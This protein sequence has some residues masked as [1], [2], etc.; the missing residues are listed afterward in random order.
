MEQRTTVEII[1]E[2]TNSRGHSVVGG[3]A[4]QIRAQNW[5]RTI[6][7]VALAGLSWGSLVRRLSVDWS[8]NPQYGYGWSVPVLAVWLFWRRWLERP[9][10]Q[11]PRA[12]WS[13]GLLLACLLL[14]LLPARLIEEANPEWRLMLWTHALSLAAV[15]LGLVYFH[16]GNSWTKHFAFPI[17]FLLVSVPWPSAIEHELIQGL[18]QVVAAGTVRSLGVLGIVGVQH[19]NLIEVGNG[20]VGMDEACSGVRSL[21]TS[22]MI[23]LFLG[24]LYRFGWGRRWLMLSLGVLLAVVANFGRT[25]FLVWNAA[26]HGLESVERWHDSAGLIILGAVFAGQW[27]LARWLRPSGT[28]AEAVSACRPGVALSLP[29]WTLA[30]LTMWLAATE[31]GTE[32]WY[33]VHERKL[34]LSTEWFL[35]WPTDR[36]G[37]RE[38]KITDKARAIL[39]CDEGRGGAWKD[40]ARNFWLVFFLEWKAGRNSAQLAKGHTPDI[41]MPATGQRLVRELDVRTFT[42]RGVTLPFRRYEFTSDGRPLYVFHCIWERATGDESG[43]LREDWSAGSR[44]ESV[45]AGR[46]HLGQQ[47]LQIAVSGPKSTEAA[48]AALACE[49]ER[50]LRL[51]GN[52]S[53]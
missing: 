29:A 36:G 3:V 12:R 11:A 30:G 53:H 45:R 46:R 39:R 49:L 27:L 33:R 1:R 14:A 41:C 28:S 47:V 38:I 8:V 40:E 37:F 44:L 9:E 15:T 24:E 18:T 20:V 52:T 17:C 31:L 25:L 7:W 2:T 21:Q 32:V 19:G 51:D 5:F 22:V 4:G 16:G 10:P 35:Q 13:L 26:R 48:D 23:S 50:I 6:W 43:S 34:K 42:V